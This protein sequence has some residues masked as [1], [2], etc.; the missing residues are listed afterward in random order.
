MFDVLIIGGGVSGVSCA[1]ILGSAHK[2][3]FAADKK[4]GIIT[5]QKASSLQDAIFHNAYG[6]SNGKLGSE[7]LTESTEHLAEAYPH[8]HQIEDEKVMKVEGEAGN[9]TVTTNKNSYTAKTIVIGIGS[10]NLFAIDGLT[11]YIEPHRKSLAE[12]N[13]IQLKNTDHKVAEGIYV[14]GTL[15][16]H[17]SQFSIAA[18][19]GAAVAT[20]ILVL[21][22]DGVETHSHDSIRK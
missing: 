8:V 12:K 14:C 19:S 22:N 17:R 2:K 1:L 4:I 20:D 18:G 5:H 16:G 10:S 9:F 21:W 6:V 11:Q 13:R 15:A 7:I 3:A